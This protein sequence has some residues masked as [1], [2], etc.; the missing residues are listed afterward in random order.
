MDEALLDRAVAVEQLPGFGRGEVSVQDAGAQLAGAYLDL[1]AGQTV[2]DACAAP[3]GKTLDVLQRAA[4][5]RVTALDIDPTRLQ[6]VADNLSR[7]GLRGELGSQQPEAE[8]AK[9]EG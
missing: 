2:L 5:L 7:A 1:H 3:G 8:E 6:R 9:A 4:G